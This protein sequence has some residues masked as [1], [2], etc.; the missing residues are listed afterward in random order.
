MTRQKRDILT[1]NGRTYALNHNVFKSYFT[2]NP[3]RTPKKVGFESD[4]LRG[5]YSEFK[6]VDGQLIAVDIR[7]NID[8]DRESGNMISKSVIEEAFPDAKICE[9][10]S[11]TLILYSSPPDNNGEYHYLRMEIA[12]GNLEEVLPIS[13]QEYLDFDDTGYGYY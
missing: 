8:F 13:Y 4:L 1:Y 3:E 7:V 5:Y 12:N 11:G 9:W 10:F 2:A 6:I